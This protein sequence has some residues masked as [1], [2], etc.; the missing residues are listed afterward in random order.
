MKSPI[1]RM[2]DVTNVRMMGTAIL[3]CSVT[4]QLVCVSNAWKGVIAVT[5][6]SA[7]SLNALTRLHD[8]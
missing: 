1:A 4:L 8:T 6:K 2:A 7:M 3:T 5:I